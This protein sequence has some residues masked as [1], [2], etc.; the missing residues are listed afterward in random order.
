MTILGQKV[1]T[2]TATLVTLCSTPPHPGA[3]A[4]QFG[5]KWKGSFLLK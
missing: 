3:L 1:P 4:P 5:E 2:Y